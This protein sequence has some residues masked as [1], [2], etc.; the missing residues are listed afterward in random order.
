[1]TYQAM[2]ENTL[3]MLRNIS[4]LD[5]ANYSSWPM[6]L[7]GL[8]PWQKNERSAKEILDEYNNFW[9]K[10][11]LNAWEDYV[12]THQNPSPSRFFRVLDRVIYDQVIQNPN[13]YGIVK[14]EHLISINHE[15]FIANWTSINALY[16]NLLV[17][18]LELYTNKYNAYT[19]VELGC[20]TGNNLFNAYGRLPIEYILGAEIC[21]NAVTLGNQIIERCN[22]QG[23]FQPFDYFD[24]NGMFSL[25][26][27]IKSKYILFTSHS[28]EQIQISETNFIDQLL[29][30]EHKPEIVIHFEPVI[31]KND[32]SL[33]SKL[34]EV[35]AKKNLY[36]CDLLDTLTT[37]QQNGKINIIDIQKG[38]FGRGAFNPTTIIA[39][40]LQPK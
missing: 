2:K 24:R 5:S 27:N 22:I 23:S 40:Q 8:T 16:D 12:K 35:Y 21:S 25:I 10:N 14:D 1:M 28:I 7:V 38:I 39:Y 33:V 13:I 9:Y 30:I 4:F 6:R 20:G 26:Q 11:A 32:N 31:D 17:D 19:L 15:L 36:N 29:E 3:M 18:V 37:Y 34:H